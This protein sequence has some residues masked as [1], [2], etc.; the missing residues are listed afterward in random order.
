[1]LGAQVVVVER[2][3]GQDPTAVGGLQR[4][5]EVQV[6]ARDEGAHE[7]Q[8]LDVTG[9]VG[10]GVEVEGGLA[11]GGVRVGARVGV[12]E[13][14]VDGGVVGP[15]PADGQVQADRETGRAEVVAGPDARAQQQPRGAD[16]PGRQ[17]DLPRL[18]LL[19]ALQLDAP[20][21]VTVEQDPVDRGVAPNGGRRTGQVRH[22]G[23]DTHPVHRVGR[24]QPRPGRAAGVLVRLGGEAEPGCGVEEPGR[25]RVQQV[26]RRSTDRYRPVDAV[27][28]AGKV[29]VGLGADVER[30]Q[31]GPRPA[32]DVPAVGVGGVG[33]RPVGAVD[34]RGTS[35]ASTPRHPGRR[36]H[37][38]QCGMRPVPWMVRGGRGERGGVE[39]LRRPRR[40]AGLQQK[41]ISGQPPRERAAGGARAHDQRVDHRVQDAGS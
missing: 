21:A 2:I 17:H 18:D 27:Q 7:Q 13:R 4:A 5:H 34:R 40:R 11:A 33:A 35:E 1:M 15:A 12:G 36:P 6:P 24:H 22:R 41:D 26:T 8:H 20:G 3:K 30:Q 25:G 9:G 14:Q 29:G 37:P 31:V 19:P 10:A 39:Q 23:I 16:R 32:G 38:Q 28:R